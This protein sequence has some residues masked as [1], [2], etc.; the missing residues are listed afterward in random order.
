M[1]Y[2]LIDRASFRQE[3]F[4]IL[5]KIS[6]IIKD[7]GEIGSFQLGNLFI[8]IIQMNEYQNNLIKL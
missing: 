6:E 2:W 3:D 8:D 5:Q 4:Q 7:S 1:K